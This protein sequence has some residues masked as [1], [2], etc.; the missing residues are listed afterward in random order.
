MGC[1]MFGGL[2]RRPEVTKMHFN[3][4]FAMRW[5]IILPAGLLHMT[6][7]NEGQSDFFASQ[8]CAKKSGKT[9]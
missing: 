1:S 7:S 8:V 3:L 4:W 2:A 6:G 5:D 9:I